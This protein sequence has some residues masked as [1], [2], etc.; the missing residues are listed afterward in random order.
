MKEIRICNCGRIHFINESIIIDALKQDK[1]VMLIC[2][3]CGNATVIGADRYMDEYEPEKEVFDMYSYYA[4]NKDF[5]IDEKSFQPG[6]RKEF[7]KV[8]YSKGKQVR[9][10]TGMYATAYEYGKFSD[11]WFPDFY[12]IER[13]GITVEEIMQFIEQWRHDRTTVNMDS[14]IHDLSEE[15]AE[16]LSGRWVKGLDWS[17]TKYANDC[18][19]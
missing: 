11:N 5:Q 7:H 4:G 15:E 19:V 16:I 12:K 13:D 6:E 18:I 9:M 14:L 2:G 3:G 1:E 8:I 17:G 10:M